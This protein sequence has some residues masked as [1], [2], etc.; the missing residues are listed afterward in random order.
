MYAIGIAMGYVRENII[1]W[2]TKSSFFPEMSFPLEIRRFHPVIKSIKK[3]SNDK[4]KI[5]EKC[6]RE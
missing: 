2:G 5:N 6:M 1:D 3:S 4:G